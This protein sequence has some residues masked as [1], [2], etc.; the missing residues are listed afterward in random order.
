MADVSVS[1]LFDTIRRLIA[2]L[3]EQTGHLRAGDLTRAFKLTNAKMALAQTFSEQTDAAK[4][5]LARLGEDDA[6][7]MRRLQDELNAA[8]EENIAELKAFD[9]THRCLL[10]TTAGSA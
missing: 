7:S 9:R 8:I 6:I 2:L 5:S 10:H 4:R 3:R 1:E